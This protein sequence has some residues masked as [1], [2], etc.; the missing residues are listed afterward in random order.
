MTCYPADVVI[1]GVA[2]SQAPAHISPLYHIPKLEPPTPDIVA[3]IKTK[4]IHLNKNQQQKW[5]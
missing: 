2:G 1:S 5:L 4:Y 3:L